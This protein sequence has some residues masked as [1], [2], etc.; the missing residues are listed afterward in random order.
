MSLAKQ[1][2]Q[3]VKLDGAVDFPELPKVLDD[4]KKQAALEGWYFTLRQSVTRK[5]NEIIQ[6]RGS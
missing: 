3:T 4:P 6:N 5:L 1:P 2:D